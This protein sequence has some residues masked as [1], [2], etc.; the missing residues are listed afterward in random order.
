MRERAPSRRH[1]GYKKDEFL[2]SNRA[3]VL[4]AVHTLFE[5]H[6]LPSVREIG[7]VAG[8]YSSATVHAHLQVLAARGDVVAY[9]YSRGCAYLPPGMSSSAR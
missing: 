8:L 5:R 3:A 9:T 2:E 1:V 7:K 6:R 4:K